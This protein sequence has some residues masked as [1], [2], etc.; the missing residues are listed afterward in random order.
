[1]GFEVK[2]QIRLHLCGLT[3]KPP[4]IKNPAAYFGAGLP[5]GLLRVKAKKK[6][7]R[8]KREAT[9]APDIFFSLKEEIYLLFF[10]YSRCL[11]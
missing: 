2:A 5:G 4:K 10:S 6:Q 8:S 3:R 9:R 7:A 1:M 11:T